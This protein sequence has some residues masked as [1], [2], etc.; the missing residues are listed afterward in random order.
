MDLQAQDC[1]HQ[2][3]KTKP[4]PIFPLV[5]RNTIERK[6]LQCA[7]EKRRLEALVE[8]V[9]GTAAGKRSVRNDAELDM[10]LGRRKESCSLA[11]ISSVRQVE[12]MKKEGKQEKPLYESNSAEIEK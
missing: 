8:V 4:V 7:S 9:R 6:L 2:I 12:E 11:F 1:A 10:P 3:G 5:S